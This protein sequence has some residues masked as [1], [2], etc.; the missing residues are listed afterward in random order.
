[1]Q[2]WEKKLTPR[3]IEIFESQ[4]M[5]LLSYLGY[6]PKF[7]L[8]ARKASLP[9]IAGSMTREFF[10]GLAGKIYWNYLIYKESNIIEKNLINIPLSE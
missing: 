7:G 5:D 8:R 9:I 2:A 6:E 1:M 10:K 3:Q 4:T